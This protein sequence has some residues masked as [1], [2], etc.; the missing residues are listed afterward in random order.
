MIYS[1]QKNPTVVVDIQEPSENFLNTQ[2]NSVV[3][4]VF[5]IGI[6][7]FLERDEK[8]RKRKTG[9][10]PKKEEEKEESRETVTQ[11]TKYEANTIGK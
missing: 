6:V 2:N 3:W 8:Q 9:T 4:K 5:H 7:K 1:A 10:K 11:T